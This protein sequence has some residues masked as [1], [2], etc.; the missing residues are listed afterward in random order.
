MVD[1]AVTQGFTISI[2]E[3][4][5]ATFIGSVVFKVMSQW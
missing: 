4:N 2:G 1:T 5:I 3:N